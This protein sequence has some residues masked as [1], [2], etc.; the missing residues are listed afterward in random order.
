L[1]HHD[2]TLALDGLNQEGRRVRGDGVPQRLRITERNRFEARGKRPE[3]VAI[4]GIRREAHDGDR[5]A[6]E[7]AVANDDLGLAVGDPFDRVTP[8]SRRLDPGLDGLDPGVDR[9]RS[10]EPRQL[11]QAFQQ[12]RQLIV[13]KC[14]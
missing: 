2:A 4:L 9:Q 8:F 10:V 6:M 5:P 1:A 3:T 14:A 11:G 13:V 7:V 12:Q